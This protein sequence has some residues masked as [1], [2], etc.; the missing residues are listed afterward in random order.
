MA[1]EEICVEQITHKITVILSLHASPR[2]NAMMVPAQNVPRT[3]T[4]EAASLSMLIG[5]QMR[6]V[7]EVQSEERSRIEKSQ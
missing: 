2:K 1:G 6:T 5:L 3:F 4:T 7:C